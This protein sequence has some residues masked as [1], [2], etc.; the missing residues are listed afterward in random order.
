VRETLNHK[1]EAEMLENYRAQ[2]DTLINNG[3]KYIKDNQSM[4]FGLEVECSVLHQDGSPV[5]NED[6][7]NRIISGVPSCTPELGAG[8]IEIISSPMD[9]MN[10]AGLE[11]V[12]VFLNNSIA[13]LQGRARRD[14]GLILLSGTNP[15][16]NLDEIA[17]TQ[18]LKY[19]LVPNYYNR[20]RN[21]RAV[22]VGPNNL[23]IDDAAIPSILNSIQPNIEA[24]SINDAVDKLNRLLMI[25]PM[26]VALTANAK[27]LGLK[28]SGMADLRVKAWQTAFET[29]NKAEIAEGKEHRIGTPN[30]YYEGIQDYFDRIAE[31][32]FILDAPEQALSVGIGM[33]WKDAKIKFMGS[34][35]VVEYRAMSTQNTAEEN[36]SA[37]LFVVGRLMYS[38]INNEPLLPMVLVKQNSKQAMRFGHN[39]V[40]W[41]QT[42]NG[43]IVPAPAQESIEI[44]INK[45]ISGIE[46]C[47]IPN[48]EWAKDCI[49]ELRRNLDGTPAHRLKEIV[50]STE[51]DMKMRLLSGLVELKAIQT[52]NQKVEVG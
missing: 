25:S 10:D 46:E 19:K 39:A 14:G 18:A 52:H 50:D 44:E 31:H 36:A 1:Q 3:E 15:L 23:Q 26:A 22:G 28:D 42:E 47:E 30:S 29:R 8:Q 6:L 49:N 24:R 41:S 33:N 7:R 21:G 38:Q 37:S 20:A 34:S 4:H 5:A 45:A 51:G 9:V 11:P 16:V 12:Y 35:A 40:L 17:R 27:Y 2:V 43:S 13:K 32:P 48:L